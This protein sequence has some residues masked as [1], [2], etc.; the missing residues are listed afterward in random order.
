MEDFIEK[1]KRL[2]E[3]LK[4][5]KRLKFE[6]DKETETKS[7]ILMKLSEENQILK[8]KHNKLSEEDSE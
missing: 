6:Q 5:L 1:E 2:S 4:K 8:Q 3:E 7:D